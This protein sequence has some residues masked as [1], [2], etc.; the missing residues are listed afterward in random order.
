MSLH[1]HIE[2]ISYCLV[3]ILIADDMSCTKIKPIMFH[4]RSYSIVVSLEIR[5]HSA[6][7]GPPRT[8]MLT[9]E[10]QLRPSRCTFSFRSSSAPMNCYIM[11]VCFVSFRLIS[12]FKVLT[13]DRIWNNKVPLYANHLRASKIMIRPT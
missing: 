7:A 13:I 2:P 3:R 10:N 1:K 12:R 6:V 8:H 5:R 4:M 9:V 11:G